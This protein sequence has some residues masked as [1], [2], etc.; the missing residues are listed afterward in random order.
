[1]K[2]L[3]YLDQ[4]TKEWDIIR[5][6]KIT[7]TKLAKVM[8]TTN[9]KFELIAELIS[10]SGTEQSK[11]FTVTEEMRRGI[12]EEPMAIK[13]FEKHTGLNVESVGF[14]ISDEFD[15]VGLSPDG[16][17]AD[18]SGDYT[19]ALEVKNPNS[20][21]LIK[22][23]LANMIAEKELGL[24]PAKRPFLGIPATYKWQTINYFLVNEKL[25]KLYFASYDERFISH[26]MK[27]YIVELNRENEVLQEEIE[28]ARVSVKEFRS[29]WL[30]WQSIVLPSGF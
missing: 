27:I 11:H 22:Y 15:Y 8:G 2:V 29:T 17:I 20:A 9:D 6:C 4:G 10:E 30:K 23:K 25:R 1:M 14:C 28:R 18:S 19:S 24:T 16:L 5:R 7:G 26:D 3:K 21:T 13:A 12:A